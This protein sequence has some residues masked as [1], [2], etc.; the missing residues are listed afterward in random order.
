[1][2][3]FRQILFRDETIGGGDF[4]FFLPGENSLIGHGIGI[5]ATAAE[6]LQGSRSTGGPQN[7]QRSTHNEK[8]D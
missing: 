6:T 1:M 7:I 3:H 4:L 8:T 5:H 2:E